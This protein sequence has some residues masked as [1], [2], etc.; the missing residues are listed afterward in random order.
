MLDLLKA[1]SSS[2][3]FEVLMY[4]KENPDSN[5]SGVASALGLHVLTV[6]KIL[7]V[8]EKYGIVKSKLVRSVG[9]PSKRYRYIGG[10]IEVNVD[11]LLDLYTLKHMPVREKAF[12][13]ALYDYD[14]RRERIKR[15]LVKSD[16]RKIV[17]DETEG[18]V[19]WFVPPPDSQGKPVEEIAKESGISLLQ[20]LE[21][22]KRLLDLG[23][24]E[25][26]ES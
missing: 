2:N 22:V 5:A 10:K 1:L 26:V 9:R 24:V 20:V 7:E 21:A 3:A 18:K 11:E 15:L 4:V 19:L 17:F 12:E 6:Q 25:L 16:R 14:V 23:L 13:D 8:L